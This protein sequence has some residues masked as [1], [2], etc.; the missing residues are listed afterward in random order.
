MIRIRPLAILL[1]AFAP[2]PAG[3]VDIQVSTGGSISAAIAGASSGDRVLVQAGTYAENVVLKNGVDL[4]GGYDGSFSEGSRNPATNIT[5]ISGSGAGPAITSGPLVDSGTEVDGFVL[6]GGGGSPGTGVLVV[7]GSPVFSNNEIS[8]NL[9]AGISGG[10]Y[11]HSGSSARFVDNVIQNNSSLGSGGG[12]RVE[13]SPATLVGNTFEDNTAPHSGGGLYVFNSALACTA[14]TFRSNL[15]GEGGGGGV[16]FQHALDAVLVGNTFDDNQGPYGGGVFARDESAILLSG[17]TFTGCRATIGGGGVAGFTFA[18]L[19][20]IDNVFDACEADEAG[21][22]VWAYQSVVNIVGDD[23][24][25]ASP[26]AEFRD[27]FAS[28]TPNPDPL[29]VGGGVALIRCTG[30]IQHVRFLRCTADSIAGGVYGLHSELQIDRNV[31]ESCVAPDGGGLVLHTRFA[32][33]HKQSQVRNNTFWGNRGTAL[34]GLPAGGAT[35]MS[36]TPNV[37]RFAGNIVAN[38]LEG[39]CL[40]C[41]EGSDGGFPSTVGIFC[42]SLQIAAGNPALPIPGGNTNTCVQ[43]FNSSSRNRVE[44]PKFCGAPVD[45]RLQSCSPAVDNSCSQAGTKENRGAAPDN[46]ECACSLTALEPVSWGKIKAQYR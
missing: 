40:R 41:R 4:R 33:L 37:V 10:V 13:N 39:S 17:N 23:A 31:F 9:D 25:A 34:T 6:T 19:D 8:G 30:Q 14:N 36:S 18:E 22:G 28:G 5:T 27:C 21:G 32:A 15:A 24:T 45:Y 20:L 42:T 12:M 11:I 35:F 3:A 46:T 43:A 29:G 26:T 44:D 38:T 2:F 1:V 16:Y 7:G